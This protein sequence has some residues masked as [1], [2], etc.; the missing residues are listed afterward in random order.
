LII[1]VGGKEVDFI[2]Q[3]PEIM[4][5]IIEAQ[6]AM[7]ETCKKNTHC[8]LNRDAIIA[9]FYNV[10]KVLFPKYFGQ[11]NPDLIVHAT[12]P[13]IFETLT[14]QIQRAFHNC[15]FQQTRDQTDPVEVAGSFMNHLPKLIQL[16]DKDIQAAMRGDPA[17]KTPCEVILC[18]PGFYAILM[19]RIAHELYQLGI[20]LIPRILSEYAH[21]RTGCDIHPGAT[22]GLEFFI[23]HAT[24]VVVGETT[25][26]G[27]QVT[28]YQHVTLGALSFSKDDQGKLIRGMKR[29]P[30]VEDQVIIYSGT[31]VLG[32]NTVIGKGSVIGGNC[33]ITSSIPPFT[34]VLLDKPSMK[35][36][37][38]KPA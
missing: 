17:A 19:Y 4:H 28:L 2:K 15:A 13:L 27:N 25:Q 33:W 16:L 9:L 3:S 12:L 38:I 32:G 5:G 20:P 8:S 23:D 22:I 26:I 35:T 29:H 11:G 31:T 37:S 10:R 1:A 14:D 30:T 6:N 18:Y 24:G 36:K 34:K 21:S 7:E